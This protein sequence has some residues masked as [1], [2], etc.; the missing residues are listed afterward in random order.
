MRCAICDRLLCEHS[1]AVWKGVRLSAVQRFIDRIAI[2]L[3][4]R[5][6]RE[7]GAG[8][9]PP[10]G[11]APGIDHSFHTHFATATEARHHVF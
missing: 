6:A 3:A 8:L 4:A 10:C 9:L 1:D 7:P 2:D 5:G 11:S